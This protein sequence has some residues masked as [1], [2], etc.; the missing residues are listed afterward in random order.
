MHTR[1][2]MLYALDFWH[3]QACLRAER[4][5]QELTE[6]RQRVHQAARLIAQL[7]FE[8]QGLQE[9]VH[10]LQKRKACE[11]PLR[12]VSGNRGAGSM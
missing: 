10:E 8:A 11:S 3:D 7:E 6:E 4:R 9:R 5:A 1:M 2:H 12:E